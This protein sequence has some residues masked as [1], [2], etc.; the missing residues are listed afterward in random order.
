[1]IAPGPFL[2]R[3][4]T[5]SGLTQAELARR[6]NTTQSTIARLESSGANPRFDTFRRTIAATGYAMEIE[7]ERSTY[8]ALDETMIVSNLR[9]TPAQRLRYFASAYRDLRKFAPTVR[10]R[11]GPQGQ[12][13]G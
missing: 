9:K 2:K 13:S 6:L 4:R 7:L 3:A 10:N 8:P 12:A 1:M 5:A 11:S